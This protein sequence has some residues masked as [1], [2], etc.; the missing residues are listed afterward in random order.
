MKKRTL[1]T[2]LGLLFLLTP[3]LCAQNAEELLVVRL[4][5]TQGYLNRHATPPPLPTKRSQTA[6]PS[7]RMAS[8]PRSARA[9]DANRLSQAIGDRPR[10]HDVARLARGKKSQ[11]LL[12]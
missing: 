2:S 11:I 3:L 5:A 8:H 10:H 9:D 1:S 12:R 6:T 4:P 7:S